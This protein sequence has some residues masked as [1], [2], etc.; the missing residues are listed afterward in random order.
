MTPKLPIKKPNHLPP[1]SNTWTF[2]RPEET[3]AMTPKYP[4]KKGY[5]KLIEWMRKIYST[6][7]N[8]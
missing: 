4:W 2:P 6:T 1:K 5:Q 8:R 7:H 3:L